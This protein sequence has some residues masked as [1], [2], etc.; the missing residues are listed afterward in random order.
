MVCYFVEFWIVKAK[1]MAHAFSLWGCKLGAWRFS[2]S[3]RFE[4]AALA[5]SASSSFSSLRE[6]TDSGFQP[7]SLRAD[8][9]ATILLREAA[10]EMAPAK[11]GDNVE[12]PREKKKKGGGRDRAARQRIMQG[13][14]DDPPSLPHSRPPLGPT[15]CR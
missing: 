6:T 12:N 14:I 2:A 10:V 3:S 8:L 9:A 7:E 5:R 13:S 11:R 15:T 4:L 1:G